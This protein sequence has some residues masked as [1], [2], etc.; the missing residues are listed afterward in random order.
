MQTRENS[1]TEARILY[2]SNSYTSWFCLQEKR[3]ACVF[4]SL[5]QHCCTIFFMDLR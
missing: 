2:H 4:R 5:V 3:Q 1:V